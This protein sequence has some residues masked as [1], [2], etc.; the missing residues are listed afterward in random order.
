MCFRAPRFCFMLVLFTLICV[1]RH[2]FAGNIISELKARYQ[3]LESFQADFTQKLVRK[4]SGITEERHGVLSFQKPL[5]I[6]WQ[7][8][9]PQNELLLVTSKDVWNYLPDEEVAYRY[10]LDVVKDSSSIIMVVTGQARLDEDFMV[11]D[12][13]YDGELLKI[14]LLP[15]EPTQQMVEGLLW[16]DAEKKIIKKARITD[17]YGNEN[18]ITFTR[19]SPD[20]KFDPKE[21]T[22]T[23]PKGI[24]IED[25]VGSP[26]PEQDLLN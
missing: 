7:T 22:F 4:D 6:R 20:A 11:Q 25:R 1:P 24:D 3:Q 23:P 19:L 2:V 21:F 12:E 26:V 10:Q 16:I 14:R 17:F 5:L 13:G 15:K 8:A 18:E 9:K